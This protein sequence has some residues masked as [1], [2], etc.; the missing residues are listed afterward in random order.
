MINQTFKF[1]LYLHILF[2]LTTNLF[3]NT[4]VAFSRPGSLVRTPTYFDSKPISNYFFGVSSET[5]NT[6]TNNLAQ[7]LYFHTILPEGLSYGIVYSTHAQI[8]NLETPRSEISLHINKKIYESNQMQIV[9]GIQ[10]ILFKSEDEH[11]LSLFVSLINKGVF[12]DNEKKYFLKSG[13]G[14]G[15]GKINNDSHNYNDEILQKARVFFGFKL[16]T[17]LLQHNGGVDLLLD[18]DGQ[19]SHFGAKIPINKNIVFNF[20]L[21]NFQQLNNLNKYKE[22]LSELIFSDSPAIALGLSFMIPSQ[23]E[24][25]AKIEQVSVPLETADEQCIIT[26]TK[27]LSNAPL[28]LDKDCQDQVLNQFVKDINKD[29]TAL[30][31]SIKTITQKMEVYQTQLLE[32]NYQINMLQD[33]INMQYLKHRISES[34]LNIAMKHLSQSLQYFYLEDYLSALNQVEKVITRFPSLA[35]AYARKGTIY[36]KM[37]DIQNATINWNLALKHDPEYTEVQK[38]LLNI[39]QDFENN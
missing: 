33:S 14:F 29:F 31:D 7:S 16:N 19:G 22:P 37:G 12:L 30:N 36:Y 6:E 3:S 24:S 4:R 32:N 15:S 20:A 28:S 11:E 38:M 13:M 23:S 8:N 17:P 35:I 18:Y 2:F 26:Q 9:G 25:S 5:I 27:E 34:E 21:T 10:D 39:K 1:F